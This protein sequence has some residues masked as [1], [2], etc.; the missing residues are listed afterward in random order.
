[1]VHVKSAIYLNVIKIP[2]PIGVFGA[3]RSSKNI[4]PRNLKTL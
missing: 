1:M 3:T 4:H 2:I